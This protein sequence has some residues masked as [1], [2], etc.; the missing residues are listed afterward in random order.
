MFQKFESYEAKEIMHHGWIA[1]V[2]AA[3]LVAVEVLRE[4]R[5][6][7]FSKQH[8]WWFFFLTLGFAF[9][10]AFVVVVL[11]EDFLRLRRKQRLRD[12]DDTVDGLW[13][14]TTRDVGSNQCTRAS[15]AE[16][17]SSG[18]GFNIRGYSYTRDELK[19]HEGKSL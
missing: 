18:S 6:S 4:G 1:G 10:G 7:G 19:M 13:A 16:I 14:Y 8:P 3:I 11:W 2:V 12:V 17:L 15:V 9:I 5:F